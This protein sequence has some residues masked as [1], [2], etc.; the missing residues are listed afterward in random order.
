MITTIAHQPWTARH[1]A[2]GVTPDAF[3]RVTTSATCADG[4]AAVQEANAAYASLLRRALDEGKTLR[5]VGAGWSL[6]DVALSRH[7]MVGTELTPCVQAKLSTSFCAPGVD[8]RSFAFVQAGAKV[9]AVHKELSKHGRCLATSGASGGQTF[10]GAISTGT[11]GAAFRFGAMPEMVH[12][13]HLLTPSRSLVLQRAGGPIN[14]AFAAMLGA[15]LIEDGALFNAALVSMGAMGILAAFIVKTRPEKKLRVYTTE[16]TWSAVR[17]SVANVDLAV[18]TPQTPT[19][20]HVEVVLDPHSGVAFLRHMEWVDVQTPDTPLP[21]DGHRVSA[22]AMNLIADLDG[23]GGA[24]A[25]HLVLGALRTQLPPTSPMVGKVGQVFGPTT[26]RGPG[27]STEVGCRPEDAG[28]IVDRAI[29][30]ARQHRILGGLALRFVAATGAT[31]GWTRFSPVT[32]TLE[33]PMLHNAAATAFLHELSE[34]LQAYPHTFHWGQ[35]L[36]MHRP[37]QVLSAYGASLQQWRH[38]RE[39]LLSAAERVVLD[40]PF[41]RTLGL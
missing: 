32:A 30:L 24:V 29:D 18:L 22:D 27:I 34:D 25:P 10:A 38:A 14:G 2:P 20:W 4:F 19:P 3:F 1:K 26:L 8:A 11:H 33:T 5:A 16:T 15:E 41:T 39:S 36:P 12:A 17:S 7:F 13:L 21:H 31:L 23:L 40:T 9:E 35:W 6:S 28:A 37:A